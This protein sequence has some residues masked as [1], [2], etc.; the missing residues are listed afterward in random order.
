[1][2]TLNRIYP[3]EIQ[4]LM[5]NAYDNLYSYTK[6][7]EYKEKLEK[8]RD[9]I[10]KNYLSDYSLYDDIKN[11]KIRCNVFLSYYFYPKIFSNFEW[12]NIFDYSLTH[13]YLKWG[14]ISSLSI[15]DKEFIPYSNEDNYFKNEGKSMHNGDSWIFINNIAAIDL[16][17]LNREK[18]GNII[19]SIIKSNERLIKMIGTL[20]ERS[21]AYE[22]KPA[23]ALHQLWS[24]STY[25]ELLNNIK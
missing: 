12:E 17:N 10:R 2:D 24:I 13:L 4:F 6:K 8:I 9:S 5:A 15:L 3:I 23:G 1:M 16:Y 11:K 21:S 18:Y 25:I 14:G 20:P 19:N 22:L 7:E